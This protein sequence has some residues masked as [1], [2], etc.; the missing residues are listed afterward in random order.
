MTAATVGLTL[1]KLTGQLAALRAIRGI[2]IPALNHGDPPIEMRTVLATM[3]A[4]LT[5]ELQSLR[6]DGPA[7][8]RYL[9]MFTVVLKSI[10]LLEAERYPA[11]VDTSPDAVDA[12]AARLT[13]PIVP[14][15]GV[16]GR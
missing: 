12:I 15:K 7:L 6:G 2:Q 1:D 9:P 14:R 13:A 10:E 11:P 3:R 16:D 5:T 8:M 4:T